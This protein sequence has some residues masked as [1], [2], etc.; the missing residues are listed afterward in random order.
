MGQDLDVDAVLR[1]AAATGDRKKQLKALELG[2]AALPSIRAGLSH[3]DWK[4]RRDCLRF[5]DHH[6]DPE[7][8]QLI[9]DRLQDEHKD[10]RK[11]AAHALGCAHCKEEGADLGFDP[12]PYLMDTIRNDPSKRVRKSAVLSLALNQPTAPHIRAFLIEML[13][14]ETDTKIRFAAECGLLRYESESSGQ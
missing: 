7:S 5:L 9:V 12:A 13:E 3:R 6:V 4:V 10:V 14:T 8:A 11:W 2:K 1:E